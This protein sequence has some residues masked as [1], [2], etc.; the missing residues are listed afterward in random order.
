MRYKNVPWDKA[1]IEHVIDLCSTCKGNGTTSHE[2]MRDYHKR[3]YDTE[4]KQCHF[5]HG[6]GRV[7]IYTGKIV[8]PF[9]SE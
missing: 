5:C 3:E 7:V 8:I 6:S 9:D 1:K 4:K 2:V